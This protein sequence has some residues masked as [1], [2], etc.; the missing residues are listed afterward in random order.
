MTLIHGESPN[1]CDGPCVSANELISIFYDD[2]SELGKFQRVDPS[3]VP[4]Y[5]QELL[6]HTNHMTVTVE[7]HHSDSVD[8]EVLRSDVV[9]DH[10]RREILLRTHRQRQVVQYGIVRLNM[11]FLSKQ[12]RDEI[13]AQ[14]KPLGRVLIEHDV[15]REIELFDLLRVVCGPVLARFFDV[16]PGRVTFG[17]TALLHCDDEPAIELLEIVSPDS[18]S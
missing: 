18:P 3:M 8:V 15:L 4:S 5:Y 17:R 1:P 11:R 2:A 6:N 14:Q 12:P 13:L 9:Q 10:Y 16:L 7:K